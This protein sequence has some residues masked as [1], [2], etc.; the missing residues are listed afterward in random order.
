MTV[1]ALL[2]LAA[3]ATACG[4][5]PAPPE[6]PRGVG[7]LRIATVLDAIGPDADLTTI[8]ARFERPGTHAQCEQAAHGACVVVRCMEDDDRVT[9]DA[10]TLGVQTVDERFVQRLEADARGAYSFGDESNVFVPGDEISVEFEGGEVPAFDVAG[11]FPDPLGASE[12][13]PPEDG[14][15][16]EISRAADFTLRWSPGAEETSL[17]VSAGAPSAWNLRCLVPAARGVLT[18][19][20]SALASL[21]NG[22]IEV[23][24]VRHV[25]ARVGSYDMTLLLEA[26]VVD[27][28]GNG[29]TFALVP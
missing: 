9:P 23:R 20:A 12:P 14:G 11:A 15:A 29:R 2:S 25:T 5:E 6:S 16:T 19:P 1:R 21:E 18:V 26:A 3:F 22:R 8:D 7:N 24:T 10:G 4:G 13:S 27:A 17:S 28:D